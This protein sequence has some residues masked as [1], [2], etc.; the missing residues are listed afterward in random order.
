MVHFGLV[1]SGEGPDTAVCQK[2]RLESDVSIVGTKLLH[3]IQFEIHSLI[4]VC[5]VRI[6][7]VEGTR[8]V[9]RVPPFHIET[10]GLG[11]MC[12]AW[13]NGQMV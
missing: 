11:P 10:K 6:Q 3:S 4:V 2:Q 9:R 5:P 13:S 12:I 8:Q 7:S 1:G